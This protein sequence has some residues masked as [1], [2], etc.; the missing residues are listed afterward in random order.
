MADCSGGIGLSV[1]LHCGSSCSLLRPM[2]GR[3]MRRGIISS[4]QSAA[5][6]EI[7]R[8]AGV[9]STH[10]TNAVYSKYPNIYLG[11]YFFIG[12]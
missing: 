12:A 8:C 9:E 2:D 1:V 6:C 3:I 10:E 11:L 7:V 4:R 5:T